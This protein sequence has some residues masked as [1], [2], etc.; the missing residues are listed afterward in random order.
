MKYLYAVLLNDT[1]RY[2]RTE[3]PF[4]EFQRRQLVL[5]ILGNAE[6]PGCSRPDG[7]GRAPA[8]IRTTR[9]VSFT[10]FSSD[11]RIGVTQALEWMKML[12]RPVSSDCRAWSSV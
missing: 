10:L 9:E 7:R 5:G 8:G 2:L 3:R 1:H 4:D 6:P 12:E 11:S